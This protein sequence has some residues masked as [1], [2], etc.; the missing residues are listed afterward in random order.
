MLWVRDHD[1]DKHP[2]VLA[3]RYEDLLTNREAGVERI[4]AFCGIDGLRLEVFD[5]RINAPI[6]T[7][8]YGDFPT[9]Y[10]PPADLKSRLDSLAAA[11]SAE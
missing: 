8:Q 10:V 9:G 6:G 2:N 3:I 7:T 5:R 1:Y 4:E 11:G